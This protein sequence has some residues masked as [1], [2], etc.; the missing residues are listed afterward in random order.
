MPT[1]APDTLATWT[2]GNWTAQPTTALTGFA[3]DTRQVKAGQIFVALK[4]GKRDGHDFLAAA[5]QA[6]AGAAL[7]TKASPS[8]ALPQLVV[9]DPL[10]AFQAIA[11]AH[12]RAFGGLV[13]GISG[14]AGKTSTKNLL[15]LLLG[16]EIGGV[17]A[18]QGNLNNQLGVP[19]TLTR[20]EPAAHKF[21]VVEAGISEP[22]E[23]TPLA[24]MIEPDVALITLVA[25]AHL[26]ELGD[27]EG[28]ARAKAALPAAVRPAGVAIFPRQ[29]TQ[30]A[31]FR[32]LTVRTMILEP[33]AVVRPADPAKDKVYFAVSH[34]GD[35]TAIS[36][37][38]GL[39]EPLTFTVRRVSDGMAQNAALA[40]CAA[41]W[42]GVSAPVIQERIG[43]WEAASLRG[44]L[45]REDGRLLYLDCYNANPASMADALDAF[46]TVAPA[47]EP[48][49]LVLGG[50]EELGAQ[51]E[52]FH[53]ALGRSLHLRAQDFLFLIGDHAPAV[54]AGALENGNRAEQIAVV[55][56]L[57]PIAARLKE[58]QGAVFMKGSR[59]YQLEQA[60]GP[61]FA[62]EAAHA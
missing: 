56:S 1:F 57:A 60:L 14:S 47:S 44:E 48:R 8:L 15:A 24:A 30:F 43:A 52:M 29:C 53:R 33:A 19:L 20:L 18:T 7:V 34:R 12:R 5:E 4:T 31:A 21:A 59:R 58:F 55:M 36:L 39:P 9:A 37:A 11:R 27:I 61:G 42:L 50:M 32:D 6:G 10:T 54:R 46:L 13:I 41:L 17:L 16:G 51:A 3:I 25:P 45:R 2:G 49:L 35:A 62:Q 23:M 40:V 28:V 22:G 26:D 38:Y